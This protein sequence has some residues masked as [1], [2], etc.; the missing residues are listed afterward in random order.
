MDVINNFNELIDILI[1]PYD[2]NALKNV[3][4]RFVG[5]NEYYLKELLQLNKIQNSSV[6]KIP[7][8]PSLRSSI[9]KVNIKLKGIQT[10]KLMINS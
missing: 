2:L 4:L 6:K 9:H 10:K 7:S 1:F 8:V 3:D 5:V